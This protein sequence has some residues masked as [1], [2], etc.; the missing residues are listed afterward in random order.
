MVGINLYTWLETDAE[1]KRPSDWA[2][3]RNAVDSQG[4]VAIEQRL[5]KKSKQFTH[6]SAIYKKSGN[7]YTITF[8]DSL[9]TY[10]GKLKIKSDNPIEDDEMIEGFTLSIE[11][12]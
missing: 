11:E 9:D 10:K 2:R 12:S 1:F 5:G 4:I 6:N 3:F 8:T 7:L